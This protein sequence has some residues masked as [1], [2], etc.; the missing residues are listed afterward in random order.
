MYIASASLHQ[1]SEWGTHVTDRL[2]PSPSVGLCVCLSVCPESV[3][4]QNGWMDPDTIWHGEEVGRGMGVLDGDG[5]RRRE[6]IVFGVNLGRPI[7]TNVE[8]VA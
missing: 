6:G 3:L 4:W 1:H 5:Y 2:S 8:V 7:V